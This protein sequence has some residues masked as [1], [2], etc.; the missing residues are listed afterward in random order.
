MTPAEGLE[1]RKRVQRDFAY[2]QRIIVSSLGGFLYKK[3]IWK[4]DD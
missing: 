4:N 2:G 1:F 3:V